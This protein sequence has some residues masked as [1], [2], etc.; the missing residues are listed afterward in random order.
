MV[1]PRLDFERKAEVWQ[2]LICACKNEVEVGNSYYDEYSNNQGA[3]RGA[4][5]TA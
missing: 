2:R 1:F 4:K 5:R 3:N